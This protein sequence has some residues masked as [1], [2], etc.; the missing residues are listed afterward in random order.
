MNEPSSQRPL[1]TVAIPVRNEAPRLPG[2]LAALRAQTWPRQAMQVIVVDGGSEDGTLDIARAAAQD[3]PHILFLENPRQVAAAALNRALAQAQG[4]YFLRLD[5]RSRPGPEYIA[6]CVAWL[7]TGTGAG[8]AG[9]QIAVGEGPWGEAIA[10]ALNHPLGSGWSRYRHARTP[11]ESETLYLG[12]YLTW[13]LQKVG[14]WDEGMVANEDYDL[15]L[16]LRRAGARLLVDPAIPMRYLVRDSPRGLARQYLRY[17]AWR[18]VTWRKHGWQGMRWRHGAPA[19]WAAG[20]VLALALMPWSPWPWAI[21]WGGYAGVILGASLQSAR[22]LPR[23]LGRV[24]L[25]MVIIH[26]AWATGFWWGLFR[27]LSNQ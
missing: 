16:R 14:G 27:K 11:V 7:Q 25:A 20:M 17:G 8:V 18:V 24:V 10:Q 26:L 23:Q 4:R 2:L 3:F 5:A 21:S 1:V 12:A 15:N 13:W 9:P 6:R 22:P 19:L